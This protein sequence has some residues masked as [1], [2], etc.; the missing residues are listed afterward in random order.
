MLIRFE[1][2]A[3]LGLRQVYRSLQE[4]QPHW[5]LGS[6]RCFVPWPLTAGWAGGVQARDVD[7]GIPQLHPEKNRESQ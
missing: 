3:D 1:M 4:M 7:V 5:L 2:G 6:P